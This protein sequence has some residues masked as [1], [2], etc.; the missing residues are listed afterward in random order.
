M[1]GS[2]S[3]AVIRDHIERY[4]ARALLTEPAMYLHATTAWV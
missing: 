4:F 3:G 2:K 1:T